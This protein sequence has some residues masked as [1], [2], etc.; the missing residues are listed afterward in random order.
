MYSIRWLGLTLLTP[1]V[2]ALSVAR[3]DEYRA[4]L[5]DGSTGGLYA[6]PGVIGPRAACVHLTTAA[7][8]DPEV[9]ETLTVDTRSVVCSS[10]IRDG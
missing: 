1:A 7:P 2:V 8:F 10:A 6:L 9:V 4:T 3:G 5:G